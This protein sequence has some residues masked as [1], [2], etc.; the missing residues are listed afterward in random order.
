[1]VSSRKTIC[2]ILGL[3]NCVYSLNNTHIESRCPYCIH[4]KLL[5][6]G[7]GHGWASP[8]PL[9][10]GFPFLSMRKVQK[11][12]L[13][14]FQI[15]IIIWHDHLFSSLISV[16]QKAELVVLWG[17]SFLAKS[18]WCNSMCPSTGGLRMCPSSEV[19]AYHAENH[20]IWHGGFNY[21]V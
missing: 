8:T 6:H 21:N 2:A 3:L 16:R 4:N 14:T 10:F 7:L 17:S 19:T 18:L 9:S 11:S 1:M 15:L 13:N 12:Y 5:W 20:R